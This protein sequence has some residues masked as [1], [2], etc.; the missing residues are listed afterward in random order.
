MEKLRKTG[1][2]LMWILIVLIGFSIGLP[3]LYRYVSVPITPMMIARMFRQVGEG[4]RMKLAYQ[5]VPIDSIEISL[6][7]SVWTLNDERFFLH[8]GFLPDSISKIPTI[9]QQTAGNVFLINNNTVLDECLNAYFTIMIETF[10]SKERILETYLN[11]TEMS[12][13]IYGAEALSIE[14]FGCHATDL[15]EYQATMIALSMKDIKQLDCA[16]PTKE[17]YDDQLR[18]LKQIKE[19]EVKDRFVFEYKENEENR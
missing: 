3:I 8:N 16:N 14:K 7:E 4:K 12:D 11:T 10:W 5:W 17:M 19:I 9:S 13:G 15:T 1:R 18:L 2:L 6:A